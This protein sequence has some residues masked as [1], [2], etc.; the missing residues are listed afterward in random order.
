MSLNATVIPPAVLRAFTSGLGNYIDPSR[1]LWSVM[2]K[3]YVGLAA[4]SLR[5]SEISKYNYTPTALTVDDVIS[6]GWRFVAKDADLYGGCHVGSIKTDAPPIL[7]GFSGDAQILTFMERLEDLPALVD[8]ATKVPVVGKGQFDLRVLNIRWLHFEAFWL[9]ATDGAG[10]TPAT[11]RAKDIV[12]PYAG[13]V[14]GPPNYLELMFP[15]PVKDFLTAIWPCVSFAMERDKKAKDQARTHKPSSQMA[16]ETA[17][18]QK[19][20]AEKNKAAASDRVG[21]GPEGQQSL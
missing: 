6:T 5:L 17:R 11:L 18:A 12:I 7:T 10:E 19:D 13:F 4:F 20:I 14:E 15:Y 1:P 8:P 16:E 21:G 3:K 9:Y 2:Q